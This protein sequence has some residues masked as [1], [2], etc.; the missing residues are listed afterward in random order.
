MRFWWLAGLTLG[1]TAVFA[2][3]ASPSFRHLAVQ[4]QTV[5]VRNAN[6][7]TV[8]LPAGFRRTGPHNFN[9]QEDNGYHFE[10]SL[11]SYVTPR[12][13]V[14]VV[15]ERLVERTALNYDELAAARW[16]DAGFLARAK[17]CA[18]LTAAQAAQMPEASGMRWIVAAGFNPQG[19]YAFEGDL[20]VTP[21]RRH[22]ASIEL[23]AQ[24]P[25]CEDSAAIVT[26]LDGLRAQVRVKRRK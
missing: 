1:A 20:L 8:S 24:V 16:P 17:G 7:M 9:K 19:T 3:N 11:V 25:S 12:A 5:A 4:G 23:I 10:V 15:A 21:D 13:V 22:E 26:A 18:T 6:G 2:A 14:S